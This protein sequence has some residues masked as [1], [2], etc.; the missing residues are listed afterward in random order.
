MG[1]ALSERINTHDNRIARFMRALCF[2]K[3]AKPGNIE[4]LD[5][6]GLGIVIDNHCCQPNGKPFFRAIIS[7]FVTIEFWY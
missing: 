7:V 4:N 6:F 3:K 5:C 2:G 1:L